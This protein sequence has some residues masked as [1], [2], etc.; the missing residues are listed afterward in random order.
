MIENL[1]IR[2]GEYFYKLGYIEKDDIDAVRYYVEVFFNEYFQCLLTVL[3]GYLI[4]CFFET[5]VYL[6][7]FIL[8]RSYSGGYHAKTMLM[9]NFISYSLYFI[10]IVTQDMLSIEW[11]ILLLVISVSYLFVKGSC[12]SVNQREYSCR[13][14]QTK[15]M[16]MVVF[17]LVFIFIFCFD[18]QYLGLLSLVLVQVTLLNIAKEMIDKNKKH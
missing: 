11:I 15:K 1:G 12:Y 9:C 7:C 8:L 2:L 6:I 10:A 13:E 3:I 5:V 17:L 4:G 18:G 16:K 14:S